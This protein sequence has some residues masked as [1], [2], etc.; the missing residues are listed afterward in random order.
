MAGFNV[1]VLGGGVVATFV[2]TLLE[3]IFIPLIQSRLERLK[4]TA[5][6]SADNE[7]LDDAISLLY[8]LP[9]LTIVGGVVVSAVAGF[10]TG[11]K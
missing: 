4:D 10:L 7:T 1:K 6:T 2:V 11:M 8:I 9:I 5:P 3:V